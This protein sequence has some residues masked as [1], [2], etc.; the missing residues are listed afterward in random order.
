M[1]L[2]IP[3]FIWH[4]KHRNLAASVL[5]VWIII[6][7]LFNVINAILWPTDDTSKWWIGVG[8][9]DVE[10][11]FL[12]ACSVGVA[13]ALA[14]IMRS[15]A[16]VMNTD[17]ASLVPSRAQRRRGMIFNIFF[18]F[19][20]PILLTLAHL[21]VQDNRYDIFAISGCAPNNDSSWVSV[22]LVFIW[23]PVLSFLDAYYC[24]LVII[25]LRRYR[26]Q[27]SEILVCSNTNKS[28]FYRLFI[29]STVLILVFL[30]IQ[31]YVFYV[32]VNVPLN[33]FSFSR[34]HGAS[35]SQILM[36]PTGGVV[37][38]DRWVYV[39]AGLLVFFFFGLGRDAVAMY[40][41]WL[42]HIG[43]L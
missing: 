20:C 22:L 37:R 41:G 2:C 23:P 29:I 39:A 25:R 26:R 19:I 30:P 7:N 13:G 32:N 15:L 35:W 8:L 31:L 5:I 1:L 43:L 27:F 12:V 38:F 14:C 18:C 42:G 3:P 6:L 10:I 17:R 33:G 11:R 34:I 28:Q 36:I 21:I 24:S 16:N 40:R 4:A 9:C